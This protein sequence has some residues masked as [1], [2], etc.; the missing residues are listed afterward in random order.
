MQPLRDQPFRSIYTFGEF[1]LDTANFRVLKGGEQQ[2]MTPRAFEVLLLLVENTGRVVSKQEIFDGVW[3]E[4]FV[5]D[6]ALTRMV[7]EVRQVLGDNAESPVYIE[8]VPK[9][10]YRFLLPVARMESSRV[11]PQDVMTYQRVSVEEEII[12]V[13]DSDDVEHA[14]DRSARFHPSEE[15]KAL[16]PAARAPFAP[17]W[18]WA[19]AAL[20]LLAVAGFGIY[21]YVP[22]GG[23]GGC[24]GRR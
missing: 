5:T 24:R 18:I 21:R 2:K 12:E 14:A 20:G 16:P 23:A 1:T 17:W 3:G 15:P 6:N 10:G 19:L 9:R 11:G 4:T 13:D 22:A 8:T 7:K